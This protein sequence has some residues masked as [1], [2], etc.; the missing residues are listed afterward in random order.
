MIF[1]QAAIFMKKIVFNRTIDT[2]NVF[3]YL[4]LLA[5]CAALFFIGGTGKPEFQYKEF[6]LKMM[7][8][9]VVLYFFYYAH[10]FFKSPKKISIDL[11]ERIV[12]LNDSV[13][14]SL[15]ENDVVFVEKKSRKYHSIFIGEIK[16]GAFY[17]SHGIEAISINS[18]PWIKYTKNES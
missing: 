2:I 4:G 11:D 6:V 18:I 14:F 8:P 16:T 5:V 15:K 13:F 12:C 1:L 17:K 7:F 9:F 10:C 3:V